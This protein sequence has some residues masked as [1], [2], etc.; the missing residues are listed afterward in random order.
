MPDALRHEVV[1]PRSGT[2]L[3]VKR[4]FSS[5]GPVRNA[6]LHAALRTG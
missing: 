1:L 6:A 2:V 5:D 3:L 4:T